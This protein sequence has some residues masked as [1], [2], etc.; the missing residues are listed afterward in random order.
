M[1]R[2]WLVLVLL[3]SG[4]G[5]FTTGPDG[6]SLTY[7]QPGGSPPVNQIASNPSQPGLQPSGGSQPVATQVSGGAQVVST[8]TAVVSAQVVGDCPDLKD[9]RSCDPRTTPLDQT[10]GVPLYQDTGV[11]KRAVY[12]F[13]SIPDGFT[14]IGGGVRVNDYNRGIIKT[15]VGPQGAVNLDITDGYYTV[16]RSDAALAEVCVRVRQHFENH[17]TLTRAEVPEDWVKSCSALASIIVKK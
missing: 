11:G 2:M 3:T 12:Q 15:W 10:L 13:R 6:R 16:V 5:S 8:A 17:W 7:T 14:L 4:C 1:K 9:G